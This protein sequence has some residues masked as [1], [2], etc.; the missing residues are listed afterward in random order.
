MP[1]ISP[2]A[3]VEPGATLADDVIVGPFAFVGSQVTL[4]G[5]CIVENNATLTGRTTLGSKC[6]VFPMACVGEATDGGEGHCFIGD[7]TNLREHVTVYGGPQDTPTRLGKDNLVMIG[8]QIGSAAQVGS[9]GIFA[10]FT[11]IDAGAVVEDFVRTSG[12]SHVGEN[13]RV[14]A[15][16]FISGYTLIEHHAPPFAMV[17]GSPGRVRGVNSQNLKRCGF[18]DQDLRVLKRAFRRLFNGEGLKTDREALQQIL[19]DQNANPHVRS[20]ADAL[21]AA[22]GQHG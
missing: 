22:G 8:S 21:E 6:L 17:Q 11:Q 14:G 9:H 20:L 5:G 2:Q 10:N 15:Y 3:I 16:T 19:N 1:K 18:G 7:G 12:F 4:E 13:A